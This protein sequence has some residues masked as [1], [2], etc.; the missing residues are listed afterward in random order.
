[1]RKKQRR[2]DYKF[3]FI[4]DS[5][6]TAYGVLSG[7]NPMCFF[8]MKSIQSCLECW[9]VHLSK[10]F[11]ADYR[12]Q[13]VSGKGVIRNMVGVPGPKMPT[14]FTRYSD[15]SQLNSYKIQDHYVPDVL[16]SFMGQNDYYYKIKNPSVSNFVKG[17][18]D[19]LQKIVKDYMI[20]GGAT[21]KIIAVCDVEYNKELCQN[22]K[23][24][25]KSFNFAYNLVYYIEIPAGTLGKE[26][27]GCIGHPNSIGQR[28][29]AE[30]V[31]KQTIKII[32]KLK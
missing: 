32:P 1:M 13:A 7:R 3:Q 11:N 9:A 22:V 17:Y 28:R 12:L 23:S 14:L 16:F 6:T 26:Y 20:Y 4:G 27:M 25:V 19:M 2:Y 10:M 24:A 18:V 21:P 5:I 29:I 30:A 15:N 31:Y 8:R